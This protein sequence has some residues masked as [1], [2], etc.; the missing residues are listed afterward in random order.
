MVG[1]GRSAL[2]PVP[3]RVSPYR[4]RA[5]QGAQ[6]GADTPR[7]RRQHHHRFPA[8]R[9]I[10][11]NPVDQAEIAC[12]TARA[13]CRPID[14]HRH[15]IHLGDHGHLDRRLLGGDSNRRGDQRAVREGPRRRIE[16]EA[17]PFD[18]GLGRADRQRGPSD[19]QPPGRGPRA[20]GAG[21]RRALSGAT[22]CAGGAGNAGRHGSRGKYL[23]LIAFR[24]RASQGSETRRPRRDR[25]FSP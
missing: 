13:K 9:P 11:E 2:R 23:D 8:R 25:G 14:N 24:L 20:H 15:P 5:A 18:R 6:R 17:R 12:R 4:R 22:G 3:T 16:K 7:S 19:R 21:V 1:R 10:S